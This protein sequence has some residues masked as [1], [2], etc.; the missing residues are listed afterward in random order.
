MEFID[1]ENA[2]KKLDFLSYAQEAALLGLA[3]L[4][5]DFWWLVLF[6]HMLVICMFLV[7][8]IELRSGLEIFY[9]M[10]EIIIIDVFMTY[11]YFVMT[12]VMVYVMCVDVV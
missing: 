2:H 12:W 9:N 5:A 3:L 7:K 11:I 10:L 8:L 6:F 4:M 1:L